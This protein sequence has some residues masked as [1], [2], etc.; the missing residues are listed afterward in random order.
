MTHGATSSSTVS[1]RRDD[2][3]WRDS[4]LREL[5]AVR[6]R[7]EK[8]KQKI[9]KH[10]TNSCQTLPKIEEE[11]ESVVSHWHTMTS[12]LQW[13]RGVTFTLR[14]LLPCSWHLADEFQIPVIGSYPVFNHLLL[15][16]NLSLSLS[17]LADIL[18]LCLMTVAAR[19]RNTFMQMISGRTWKSNV[20]LIRINLQP[21]W[22]WFREQNISS[23]TLLLEWQGY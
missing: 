19:Q 2:Y 14:Q 3:S 21:L 15:I 12:N 16:A 10:N 23:I 6:V 9:F 8:N 20:C 7:K 5:F 18:M 1:V 17:A 13:V 11:H 4:C 22:V